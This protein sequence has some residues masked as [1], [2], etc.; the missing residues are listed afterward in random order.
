MHLYLSEQNDHLRKR[1]RYL[2]IVRWENFLDAMSETRLQDEYNK[3]VCE[4]DIF[5]CLFFTKTGK[6]TE[7]EFDKAHAQFKS[8]GKP[9]IYTY[10]KHADIN[11]G[12]ACQE[13]LTS[14]WAFQ[15]KLSQLEHYPTSYNNIEDL[16]LKFRGQL[17]KL[18]G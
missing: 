12:S 8:A 5:L 4:C 16:K 3:A 15:E 1:G 17:E 9:K 2:Q 7:E 14:L 11:I 13:D 10:F 6:F 18:Y